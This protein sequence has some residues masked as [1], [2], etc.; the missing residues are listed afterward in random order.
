MKNWDWLAT[1]H[2]LAISLILLG[3]TSLG[4]SLALHVEHHRFPAMW[5]SPYSD[6]V[7]HRCP[8]AYSQIEPHLTTWHDR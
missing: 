5:G 3:A 7:I 2:V 4:Y 1:L 8:C 6:D